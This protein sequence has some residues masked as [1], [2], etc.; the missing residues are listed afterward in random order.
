MF[1]K[2]IEWENLSEEERVDILKKIISDLTASEMITVKYLLK[3]S[4]TKMNEQLEDIF[5]GQL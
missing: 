3:D 5:D 1:G 4:M 2:L